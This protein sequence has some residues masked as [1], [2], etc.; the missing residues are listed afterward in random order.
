MHSVH[1]GW[2]TSWGKLTCTEEKVHAFVQV[3]I[4]AG[5][6]KMYFSQEDSYISHY[7]LCISLL[8]NTKFPTKWSH[9]PGRSFLIST[10]FPTMHTCVKSS[11]SALLTRKIRAMIC[12]HNSSEV[13][14]RTHNFFVV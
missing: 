4:H 9:F 3:C 5:L 8:K 1:V 11:T 10:F 12:L 2:K 14:A 6:E 13:I 7:F